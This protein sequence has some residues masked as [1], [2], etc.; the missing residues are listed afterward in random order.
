MG[1][2]EVSQKEMLI[3]VFCDA[4]FGSFGLQDT[5]RHQT[6]PPPQTKV[7]IVGNNENVKSGKSNWAI[8]GTQSFG[9]Q[10]PPPP[11]LILPCARPHCRPLQSSWENGWAPSLGL[12][13]PP[14]PSLAGDCMLLA[15][16]VVIP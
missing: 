8:F 11:I 12:I 1:K 16:T 7:T 13:I 14:P 15:S 9:S 3:W 4:N 10:T 6:P 5:R 2:H